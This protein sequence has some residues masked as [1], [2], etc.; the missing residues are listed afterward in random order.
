LTA[1]FLSLADGCIGVRGTG[2]P[3]PDPVSG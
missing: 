1:V 2:Q 3:I